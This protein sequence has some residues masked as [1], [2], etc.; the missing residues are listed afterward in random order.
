MKKKIYVY[1][2]SYGGKCF[3]D[4]RGEAYGVKAGDPIPDEVVVF[5][6]RG[7]AEKHASSYS[8]SWNGSGWDSPGYKLITE[9]EIDV[10]DG[11]PNKMYGTRKT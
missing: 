3:N 2:K 9:Y 8:C 5:D 6:T 4:G 10:K 1:H 11:I 7:E